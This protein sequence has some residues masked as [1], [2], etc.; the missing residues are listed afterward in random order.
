MK[1]TKEQKIEA[2]R[3]ASRKDHE[4]RLWAGLECAAERYYVARREEGEALAR[5]GHA[6][7]VFDAAN[8]ATCW[9]VDRLRSAAQA[10][11]VDPGL[12]RDRAW[13]G[14]PQRRD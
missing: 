5:A 8:R 1:N 14:V 7:P 9:A 2:S 4:A 13:L 11:E 10:A 12:A 3:E 6:D